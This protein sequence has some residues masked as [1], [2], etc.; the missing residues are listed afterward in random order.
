M[1]FTKYSP[2]EDGYHSS[3]CTGKYINARVPNTKCPYPEHTSQHEQWWN[4]FE[5]GL[6]DYAVGRYASIAK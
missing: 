1:P 2:F 3:L 4:G 5:K 6:N